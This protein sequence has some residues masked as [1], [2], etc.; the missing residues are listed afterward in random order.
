[1]I[2]LL[3]ATP[4]GPFLAWKRGNL[5]RAIEH[6]RHAILFGLGIALFTYIVT[7]RS[8]HYIAPLMVGLGAYV[9]AGAVLDLLWRVR[10]L[11]GAGMDEVLRRMRNLPRS[12]WGTVLGH[13]G[14]GLFAIGVVCST[15]W[16]SE[17]VL[18][19][20]PG[21]KIGFAGFEL[22]FNGVNER[23]GPDYSEKVGAFDLMS[24]GN[25]LRRLEASRRNYV[26]SAMPTTETAIYHAW[27]GDFYLAI[28][29]ALKG[30]RYTVRIY[31]NPFV[32][33]IWLGCLLMVL[34]GLAS[35]SDRRLRVG[36]PK[37]AARAKALSPA[38]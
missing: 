18:A 3:I 16:K 4:V 36:A 5:R 34:G 33:F 12:G 31:F 11:D 17:K 35:L 14:V 24:K 27:S 1:M 22:V 23:K 30:G 10:A 26:D 38:E 2:P 21:E 19:M 13:L 7:R 28:G 25:L 8:G 37:R 32:R 20:D 15:S 9:A 6:L 29:D